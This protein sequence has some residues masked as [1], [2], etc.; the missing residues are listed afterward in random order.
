[1]KKSSAVTNISTDNEVIT[2][3]NV[4]K[5]EPA[6]QEKL[7]QLLRKSTEEAMG[8]LSGW[9]SA[10]IHASLDGKTVVNYAQWK[11]KEH[12]EA[13]LKN[14]EAKKYV[15]QLNKLATSDPHLYKVEAVYHV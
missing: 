7:V 6:N 4:F 15:D 8:T 10:N 3:I 14:P 5:V 13:M 2:L 1:M 11:S 12:F 9:V